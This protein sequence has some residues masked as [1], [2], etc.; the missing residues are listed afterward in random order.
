MFGNNRLNE[1]PFLYKLA[2]SARL[3]IT[4]LTNEGGQVRSNRVRAAQALAAQLG[5]YLGPLDK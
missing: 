5:P 3:F 1:V 2:P 4:N